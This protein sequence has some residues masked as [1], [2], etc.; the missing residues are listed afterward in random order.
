MSEHTETR[1]ADVDTSRHSSLRGALA[2]VAVVVALAALARFLEQTV[3]AA[4]KGTA[5]GGAAAAIEF[6]V[7][8]VLLGLLGNVVLTRLGLRDR[9]SGGFRTEFFIKTGLVLLG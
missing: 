8:A 9:L 7:Y 4:T 3:P 6:P 1:H 5:F 2:G